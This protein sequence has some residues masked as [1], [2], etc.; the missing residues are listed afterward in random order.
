MCIQHVAFS[1]EDGFGRTVLPLQLLRFALGINPGDVVLS[2]SGPPCQKKI[3]NPVFDETI[4]QA[5]MSKM[6]R[7]VYGRTQLSLDRGRT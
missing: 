6:F 3:G 2:I 7:V 4:R 1:D 5:S